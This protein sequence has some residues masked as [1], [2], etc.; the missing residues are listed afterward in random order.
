M[1]SWIE[2]SSHSTREQKYH[3]SEGRSF[4][5]FHD[6]YAYKCLFLLPYILPPQILLCYLKFTF[7][8]KYTKRGIHWEELK[9]FNCY[10]R[11]TEKFHLMLEV[12][13]SYTLHKAH[14]LIK[15]E[16]MCIFKCRCDRF[17][18]YF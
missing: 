7:N 6:K 18:G 2:K 1:P 11:K 12:C 4:T 8:T 9:R 16:F 3:F 13:T 14:N 5:A 15:R 17:G 10:L